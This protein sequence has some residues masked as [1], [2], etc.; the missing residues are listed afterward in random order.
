MCGAAAQGLDADRAA[1]GVAVDHARADDPRGEDV[2]DRLPELVRRRPKSFPT[3]CLEDPSFQPACDDAHAAYPTP[4]RPKRCSQ[5]LRTNAE[6]AA[7]CAGS[8][9]ARTASRRA[10]SIN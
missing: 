4:T 5:L 9:R 8:S 7:A 6:R 10:S 1:A 2:E 3:W